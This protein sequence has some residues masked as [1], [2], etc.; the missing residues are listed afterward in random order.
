MTLRPPRALGAFACD[1]DGAGTVAFALWVPVFCAL[2]A[3]VTDVSLLLTASASMRN[4]ANETARAVARSGLDAAA[5]EAFARDR[6]LLGASADYVI[7]VDVGPDVTVDVSVATPNISA[8]GFFDA[9]MPGGL[10]AR[11]VARREVL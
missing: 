1:E 7:N 3:V 2:L 4:T 6:L 9:A 8:F 5:A 10:N 11:A